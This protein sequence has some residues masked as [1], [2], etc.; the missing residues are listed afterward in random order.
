MLRRVRGSSKTLPPSL[1][2][3]RNGLPFQQSDA[4]IQTMHQV[5]ILYRLSRGSLDQVMDSG[6]EESAPAARSQVPRN[7]AEVC[8]SHGAQLRKSSGS[9]RSDEGMRAVASLEFTLDLLRAYPVL[10]GDVD[11]RENTPVDGKKVRHE[12]KTCSVPAELLTDLRRVAMGDR[13]IGPEILRHFAKQQIEPR[14][15]AGARDSGFRITDDIRSW[16]QHS[17]FHQG[18]ERKKYRRRIHSGIA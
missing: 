6:K 8:V 2:V 18:K 16:F 1:I 13:A 9:E 15:T 10:E 4:F 17:R 14:T 11:R 3:N 12:K 5:E 7:V